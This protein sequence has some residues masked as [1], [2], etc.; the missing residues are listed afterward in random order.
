MNQDINFSG[1][2]SISFHS[3]LNSSLLLDAHNKAIRLALE[4]IENTVLKETELDEH[5]HSLKTDY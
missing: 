2:K 4:Y 1:T 5:N 3:H